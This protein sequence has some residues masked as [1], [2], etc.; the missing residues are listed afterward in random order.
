MWG[1]SGRV[2]RAQ[3]VSVSL[4]PQIPA[5]A[6]SLSKDKSLFTAGLAQELLCLVLSQPVPLWSSLPLGKTPHAGASAMS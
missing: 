4:S 3:W 1:W 6:L 5:V 2:L